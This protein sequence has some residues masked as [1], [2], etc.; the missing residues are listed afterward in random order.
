MLGRAAMN[1][2][3]KLAR[4]FTPVGIGLQGVELVN[5]ARKEQDRI[6]EMRMNDPDQYQEYLDELESYGDFSA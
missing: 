2:F 6:N 3:G 1:P 5:Q 4:G